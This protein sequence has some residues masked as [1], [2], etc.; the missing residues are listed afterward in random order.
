[1]PEGEWAFLD[2]KGPRSL[3]ALRL[4]TDTHAALEVAGA[5]M[6]LSKTAFA[7]L[8]VEG[9]ADEWIARESGTSDTAVVEDETATGRSVQGAE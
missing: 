6:G 9:W 7:T 1:M 3:V 2:S 5:E 8:L 4:T